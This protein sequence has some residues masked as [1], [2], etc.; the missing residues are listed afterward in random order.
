MKPKSED[1]VVCAT[2]YQNHGHK[3]ID[4]GKDTGKKCPRRKSSSAIKMMNAF[5]GTV[6]GVILDTV[7]SSTNPGKTYNIIHGK[8]GVIYCTCT[9]WKMKKTCKHLVEFYAKAAKKK[10]K[11]QPKKDKPK[12]IDA[13]SKRLKEVMRAEIARLVG[14]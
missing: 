6:T 12:P 5:N 4:T 14:R 2:C 10:V 11:P 3:Y 7:V 9:A 13:D 8:D 1:N